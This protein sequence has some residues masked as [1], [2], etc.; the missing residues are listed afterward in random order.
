MLF[1]IPT[2]CSINMNTANTQAAVYAD[3]FV[4]V[5]HLYNIKLK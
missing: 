2:T 5:I 1:L 3:V 4:P